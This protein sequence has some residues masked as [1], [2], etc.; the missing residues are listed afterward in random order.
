LQE[1]AKEMQLNNTSIIKDILRYFEL[2]SQ[3][4][5]KENENTQIN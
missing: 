2:S 3:I 1:I 4:V 5:N